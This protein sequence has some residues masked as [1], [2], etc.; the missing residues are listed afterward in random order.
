MCPGHREREKQ[1][2]CSKRLTLSSVPLLHLLLLVVPL[3]VCFDSLTPLH[4]EAARDI[5]PHPLPCALSLSLSFPLTLLSSLWLALPHSLI[6]AEIRKPLTQ[7]W[8]CISIWMRAFRGRKR[9]GRGREEKAEQERKSG[10]GLYEKYQTTKR[11][12][13]SDDA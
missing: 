5:D 7:H 9:R 8:M 11:N 6:P 1:H 13:Q 2:P 4:A 10:K 12:R 3:L